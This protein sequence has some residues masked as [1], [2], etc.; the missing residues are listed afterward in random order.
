V[1]N[2]P[3]PYFLP[4]LMSELLPQQ[5]NSGQW[6]FNVVKSGLIFSNDIASSSDI[7]FGSS[8]I[9]GSGII[10]DDNVAFK[11]A[12]INNGIVIASTAV[13]LSSVKGFRL[14]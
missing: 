2:Q 14:P 10:F 3:I 7:A 1:Q 8:A 5:L 4:P 11:S 9:S 12:L 13:V 6:T